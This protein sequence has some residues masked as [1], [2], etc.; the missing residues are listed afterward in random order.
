[1]S[2]ILYTLLR[3]ANIPR[4]ENNT[5]CIF[6]D[7]SET[8]TRYQVSVDSL[9]RNVFKAFIVSNAT[10]YSKGYNVD[11]YAPK[12]MYHN[13]LGHLEALHHSLMSE[14]QRQVLELNAVKWSIA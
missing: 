4:S 14:L 8:S 5:Y 2:A 13:V 10:D 11:A 7:K 9:R 12:S 6:T 3:A 1:M